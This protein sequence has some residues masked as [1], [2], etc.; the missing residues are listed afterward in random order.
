MASSPPKT[1]NAMSYAAWFRSW[2]YVM[3][4]E[5]I[6]IHHTFDDIERSPAGDH[7]GNQRRPSA[8]HSSSPAPTP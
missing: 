1:R 7:R 6:V 4:I 3:Q 5:E 8:I 2:S